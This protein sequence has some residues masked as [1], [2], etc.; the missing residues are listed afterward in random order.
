MHRRGI[1]HRDLKPSNV[2]LCTEDDGTEV[3]KI[4]DFGIAKQLGEAE[5]HLPPAR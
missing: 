5:H 2:M 4:L 1:I 3:V